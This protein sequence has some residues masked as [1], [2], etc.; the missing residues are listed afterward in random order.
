MPR[1]WTDRLTTIQDDLAEIA[2]DYAEHTH[3]SGSP[4]NLVFITTSLKQAVEHVHAV[5]EKVRAG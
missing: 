4:A 5:I 3:R 2:E 1:T